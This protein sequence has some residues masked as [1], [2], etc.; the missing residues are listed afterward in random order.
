MNITVLTFGIL[1]DLLE[2]ESIQ[3][4][5]EKPMSV[6]EFKQ[7][8]LKNFS[9][10]KGYSNFSIAINETYVSE[11]TILKNKDVIALIPPVSGG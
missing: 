11:D 4:Q 9:K 5:L 1:S 10:L 2:K 8:L 6:S 3:M 7:Y